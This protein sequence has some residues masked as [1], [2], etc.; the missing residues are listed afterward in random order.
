[1]HDYI[2]EKNCRFSATHVA[3][4][5]EEPVSGLIYIGFYVTYPIRERTVTMVVDIFFCHQDISESGGIAPLFLT[6][7]LDGGERSASRP[8]RF[9]YPLYPLDQGL[10]GPQN[11]SGCCR[12]L[13]PD[14]PARSPSLYLLSYP[15]SHLYR[16]NIHHAVVEVPINRKFFVTW[17][18]QVL[19]IAAH[20][21]INFW[22]RVP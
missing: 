14:R 18:P 11:R 20:R 1:M 9:L 19:I 17:P 21:E 4:L 7:V 6:S 5:W 10:G 12:L 2:N 15:E 8:W 13:K 3:S 16:R 22:K